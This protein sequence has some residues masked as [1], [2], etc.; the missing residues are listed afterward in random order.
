[1]TTE[2]DAWLRKADSD[3][4]GVRR[5]LLPLPDPNAELA[6]YHC[7]QAAE[8]LVKAL[9]I[10][11]GIAHPRRGLAGHDIGLA[12]ARVPEGH[13]LRGDAIALAA[14]TPWATAF[15]YPDEDPATAAELPGASELAAWLARL[16][17]FRAAVG[18]LPPS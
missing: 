13:P 12:A 15:R 16:E 10:V 4:D 11:L 17:A 5:A 14:L 2:A 1:M 9:L 18:R 3:L 6:A 8:K 7:Q